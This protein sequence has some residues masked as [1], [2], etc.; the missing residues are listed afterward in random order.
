MSKYLLCTSKFFGKCTNAK[1]VYW[2][3]P[4]MSKT[5]YKNT[6]DSLFK[7]PINSVYI[8]RMRQVASWSE[9]YTG[10]INCD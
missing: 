7:L 3:I 8:L 6:I 4:A 5:V 10:W 9:K 1:L 2:I